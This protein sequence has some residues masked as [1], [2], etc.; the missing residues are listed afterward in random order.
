MITLKE[1]EKKINKKDIF[2]K[3]SIDEILSYPDSKEVI[4][5]FIRL[6][7]KLEVEHVKKIEETIE[8]FE[9]RTSK[10]EEKIDSTRMI[11]YNMNNTV[12]NIS[13][14]ID[15]IKILENEVKE[16]GRKEE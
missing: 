9:N 11:A 16:N 4:M 8:H 3:E 10:I 14:V 7:A 6:I 5:L 13:N 2:S 15:K 1:L 12:D